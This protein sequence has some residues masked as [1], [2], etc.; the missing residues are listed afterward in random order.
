MKISCKDSFKIPSCN[1]LARCSFGLPTLQ[2]K[3]PVFSMP[4]NA[5]SSHLAQHIFKLS[6][7]FHVTTAMHWP[8]LIFIAVVEFSASCGTVGTFIVVLDSYH[9]WSLVSTGHLFRRFSIVLLPSS[10]LCALGEA[11]VAFMYSY[12]FMCSVYH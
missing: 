2:S 7:I 1:P 6:S 5:S 10:W 12:Y 8:R 4:L 11:S 3:I 9:D